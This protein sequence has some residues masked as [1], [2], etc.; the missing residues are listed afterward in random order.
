MVRK[1]GKK[2][3][4]FLLAAVLCLSPAAG[5][6][7]HAEEPAVAT[8]LKLGEIA[9][10]FNLAAEN[11]ALELYLNEA[12]LGIQVREK[13]TGTVYSSFAE[14]DEGLNDSWKNFMYSGVTLEY[15]NDKMS[16]V[17]V[18]FSGSGAKAEITKNANGFGV[19]LTFKEGF[20]FH[21][22]AALNGSRLT[23][24]V[25]NDSIKEP[26]SGNRF[27][28]LYLFPFLGA[29]YGNHVPGYLFVPDG[30]G[31][32]IRTDVESVAVSGTYS[33]KVY[34][35]EMG[36]GDFKALEGSFLNPPE[37]IYMPV[38]GA[39]LEEGKA[40]VMGI[41]ESGDAYANI[42]AAVYGR[43]LPVN[44]I[45]AKFSYRDTFTRSL[46]QK[47]ATMVSNQINRN[48]MDIVEHFDFLTGEKA[49]Y[50]GMA[51][52]YQQYLLEKGVL[53]EKTA[54]SEVVPFYLEV[55][56]SEQEK[57][58][59]GNKTV[60]MTTGDE[61]DAIIQELYDAGITDMSVL[62]AGYSKKGNGNALPSTANF[63]SKIA[64]ASKWKQIIAKWQEKNIPVG[65][66]TNFMV[67]SSV[68]GGFNKRK[69]VAQNISE[70][71]LEAYGA[72]YLSPRYVSEKF[73]KEAEGFKK[74]GTEL[75]ALDSIGSTLYS[76]WKKNN[77]VSRQE[78]LELYRNMS[79]EGIKTAFYR[80]S[81]YLWKNAAEIYD[82][83][84]GSSDYMLF[85]DTVPF[86]QMVLKGYIDCYA[87]YSNFNADRQKEILKMVELGLYPAWIVTEED[88]VELFNTSS[89]WL[90]T[91]QFSI[92][93]EQMI[94]EYYAVADG[95]NAVRNAHMT[96]HQIL[97]EDVVMVT[98][99]N[100][101]TITVNYGDTPYDADHTRVEALSFHVAKAN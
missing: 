50:A 49:D 99:D 64:S 51:N 61:A 87:S 96:D 25:F 30:S 40:A 24:S 52:V 81:A 80:P 75:L 33:K 77:S 9:D 26:E 43:E 67:G 6:T 2:I 18:P 41:I 36:V 65:F 44:Y 29:T 10:G 63:S 17:K 101:V 37:Q 3:M 59:V 45:T 83:P 5:V 66:Y 88:S 28:S 19:E 11:E 7:V 31:A 56:L 62:L 12:T 74:T 23:V 32:L 73:A 55:L 98:Y 91:S 53:N 84:S 46:N 85:T 97:A 35:Q 79:V 20:S 100:G 38:Y 34:G 93:K 8:S 72:N 54:E 70:K 27:E 82:T 68:G 94:E 95:L 4:A 16:R 60:V 57:M 42:E 47:G 14:N 69:D 89:S 13:T 92:W 48:Q 86:M 76:D 22:D 90:Y 15:I 39:V 1:T 58:M 21:V 71:L 78:A